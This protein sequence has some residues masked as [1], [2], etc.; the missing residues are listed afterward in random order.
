MGSSSNFVFEKGIPQGLIDSLEQRIEFT[1]HFI[2]V[3][4]EDW[5][6]TADNTPVFQSADME[7]GWLQMATDA[8]TD[9]D[10]VYASSGESIKFNSG[11]GNYVGIFAKLKLTEANTDDANII[12]GLT[13]QGGANTLQDNG[14]GPPSSYSGAVLFKVDGDLHWYAEASKTTSQSTSAALVTDSAAGSPVVTYA[15]GT[16]Y[17][18]GIVW[19][20]SALRFYVNGSLQYTVTSSTY[21]STTEMTPTI[22]VKNGG[23]NVE[24]LYADWL[25]L[26]AKR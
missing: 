1:D 19:D 24:T 7:G 14:A 17:I 13:D 23:S 20:G 5:V 16:E 18:L 10:E 9:N 22:G 4:D 2:T 26:R 21:F 3:N 11:S 6:I 12:F 8:G 25:V 15:S